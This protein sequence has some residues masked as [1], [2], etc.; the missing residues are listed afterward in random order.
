MSRK[1]ITEKEL[2]LFVR[3]K[4]E[5]NKLVALLKVCQSRIADCKEAS[6]DERAKIQRWQLRQPPSV[7]FL[8]ASAYGQK[9]AKMKTK[10]INPKTY[11]YAQRHKEAIK[12][13]YDELQRRRR[14]E[15]RAQS[16]K[17]RQKSNKREMDCDDD[18]ETDYDDDEKESPHLLQVT[19]KGL[20]QLVYDIVE[21]VVADKVLVEECDKLVAN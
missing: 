11:D 16:R 10:R 20:Q 15:E 9:L 2:T 12:I 18:E 6:D 17:R 1:L 5:R 14:E 7:L 8:K 21:S 4:I 3:L 13:Y 19:Q